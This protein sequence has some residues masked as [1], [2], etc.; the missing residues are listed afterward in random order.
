[1]HVS[2][3]KTVAPAVFENQLMTK[4]VEHAQKSKSH[5][6]KNRTFKILKEMNVTD[7]FLM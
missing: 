2:T 6:F 7:H 5:F 3:K 4:V 1:V